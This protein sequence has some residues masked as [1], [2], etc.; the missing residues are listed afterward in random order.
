MFFCALGSLW[1]TAP[2][3]TQKDPTNGAVN[4]KITDSRAST[5][6][7]M[8]RCARSIPVLRLAAITGI[9]K[10]SLS[11]YLTGKTV[12]PPN[13]LQRIADALGVSATW[14]MDTIEPMSIARF[15]AEGPPF[16][17]RVH[18]GQ[19]ELDVPRWFQWTLDHEKY[20][21]GKPY[22][23]NE[24]IPVGADGPAITSLNDDGEPPYAANTTGLSDEE[25]VEV[26]RR[27]LAT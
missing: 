26:A 1:L 14:L 7:N 21:D 15:N 18:P 12:P 20:P 23:P 10:S 3:G 6:M 5:R 11:D 17:G 9:P 27:M 22:D 13:R 16:V 2:L 4:V 24:G 19:D 8:L 25:Q